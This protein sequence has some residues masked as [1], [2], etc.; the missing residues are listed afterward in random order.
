[1]SAS[2]WAFPDG[3]PPL[4]DHL[5]RS[6]L[7]PWS[8]ASTALLLKNSTPSLRSDSGMKLAILAKL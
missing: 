3:G 8:A 5:G 1:M 6:G 2:G 4:N 7:H